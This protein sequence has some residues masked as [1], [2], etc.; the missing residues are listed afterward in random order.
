MGKPLRGASL[1][2][3][4]REARPLT[5]ALA[6]QYWRPV[7][8]QGAPIFA[9][10][11]K[12]RWHGARRIGATRRPSQRKGERFLC[13]AGAEDGEGKGVRGVA[14][15]GLA[16]RFAAALRPWLQPGV[17]RTRGENGD[18]LQAAR[19]ARPDVR[20]PVHA[21]LTRIY[22]SMKLCDRGFA[23]LEGL[24]CSVPVVR[25]DIYA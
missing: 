24:E 6:V 4:G 22:V 20:H 9:A 11:G 2:G 5:V 25:C 19:K 14:F 21:L 16:C 18:L 13:P 12:T 8:P 10:A 15:H 23:I 17:L 7:G 3:S 1:K